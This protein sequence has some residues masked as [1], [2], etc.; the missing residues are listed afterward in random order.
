MTTGNKKKKIKNASLLLFV[1]FPLSGSLLW[2]LG[3]WW[4][5]LFG[6]CYECYFYRIWDENTEKALPDNGCAVKKEANISYTAWSLTITQ[7]MSMHFDYSTTFTTASKW[8]AIVY[9]CISHTHTHKDSTRL[10]SCEWFLRFLLKENKR[11]Q[12]GNH[13]ILGHCDGFKLEGA[14]CSL[15]TDVRVLRQSLHVCF[16]S[17]CFAFKH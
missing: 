3:I 11:E 8:F 16:V 9:G 12:H 5:V 4:V 6:D 17:L 14:Q 15:F 7:T 10:D 13:F 1:F 2:R